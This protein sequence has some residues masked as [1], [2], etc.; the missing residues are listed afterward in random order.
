[1]GSDSCPRLD[2][3]I[4]SQLSRN[5]L[6]TSCSKA[7]HMVTHSGNL[8]ERC[9][10]SP[11]CPLPTFFIQ[12]LF[13]TLQNSPLICLKFS[14]RPQSVYPTAAFRCLPP[15]LTTHTKGWFTFSILPPETVT[16]HRER[17]FWTLGFRAQAPVSAVY[18]LRTILEVQNA[19]CAMYAAILRN[20][21]NGCVTGLLYKMHVRPMSQDDCKKPTDSTW[22]WIKTAGQ[23]KHWII[24]LFHWHFWG[25]CRLNNEADPATCPR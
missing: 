13:L 5:L 25:S 10:L 22:K 12:Q 9:S 8:S 1:M 17:K 11:E 19:F 20:V 23:Q 18:H 15:Y 2:F 24:Q 14:D 7:L 16:H 3:C 21:C 4:P 6:C